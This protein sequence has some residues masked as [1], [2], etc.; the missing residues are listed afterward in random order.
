VR[1]VDLPYPFFACLL[2]QGKLPFGYQFTFLSFQ[3][4]YQLLGGGKIQL[5]SCC[6]IYKSPELRQAEFAI[7]VVNLS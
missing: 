2:V 6:G 3:L 1:D 7:N 5:S 4:R